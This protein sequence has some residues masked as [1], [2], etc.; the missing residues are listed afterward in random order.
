MFNL[1]FN[2]NI[3][4]SAGGLMLIPTIGIWWTWWTNIKNIDIDLEWLFW[5]V[6]VRINI[7]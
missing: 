1:Y 4:K 6:G 7:K 3:K 2:T 5:D